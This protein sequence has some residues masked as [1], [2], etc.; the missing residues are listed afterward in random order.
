MGRGFVGDIADF[1][2]LPRALALALPIAAF[3]TLMALFVIGARRKKVRP[4]SLPL[5]DGQAT[6]KPNVDPARLRADLELKIKLADERRDGPRL[7]AMYLDLAAALH[8]LG[9]ETARM[10]ALRSAAGLA[11]KHGA[12]SEH[13]RA[14]IELAESAFAAGDLTSACEQWQI[15]RTA[16]ADSGDAAGSSRVDQRMRDTGC[17]TDWVLTDF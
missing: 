12:A 1:E 7:A 11:A 2:G 13:A 15:A 9:D 10:A 5:Y 8:D 4:R 16:L 17:P 3:I 14:R 6:A